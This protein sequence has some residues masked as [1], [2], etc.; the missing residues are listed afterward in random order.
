MR[1]M[2]DSRKQKGWWRDDFKNT[3]S[4]P[5]DSS[6]ITGCLKLRMHFIITRVF[7]VVVGFPKQHKRVQQDSLG[8]QGNDWKRPK[9]IMGEKTKHKTI[10]LCQFKRLGNLKEGHWTETVLKEENCDS[11]SSVASRHSTGSRENNQ[12]LNHNGWESGFLGPYELC[13][14]MNWAY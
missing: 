12:V 8:F 10:S 6:F 3:S 13:T 4:P 9:D 14:I 5:S 1:I 2:Q 7:Q 11:A